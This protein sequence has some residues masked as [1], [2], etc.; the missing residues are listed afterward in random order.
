MSPFSISRCHPLPLQRGAALV[1]V[2]I[3]LLLMTLLGL[4]SLRGTLLEERMGANSLDRSLGFQAAEA[5]LRQ[6][7][8]ALRA[9]PVFP[10]AGCVAGLCAAP[11]GGAPDRWTDP[12]FNGWVNAAVI[13]G[14]AVV[15]PQFFVES[16]GNGP[17]TP[18]CDEGGED[19][20]PKCFSPRFRISARSVAAGRG[21]IIL[22]SNFAP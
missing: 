2:L 8:T 3:L 6:A 20:D 5:A 11:V 13:P 12:T 16:L 18:G 4:A 15:Q 22:Q 21:Q 7:E 9:L 19:T 10:P 14:A 1:V 17:N